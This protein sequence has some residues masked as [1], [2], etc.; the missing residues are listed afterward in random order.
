VD[1]SRLAPRELVP[2]ADG[3][4][5]RFGRTVLVFRDEL[6]GPLAPAPPA[7]GLLVGPYGLRSVAELLQGLGRSAPR[8]VLVEG[9]TG[10]GKELAARAV[11]AAL[12]RAEPFGAVNVAALAPGVFESHVFGHVAGAFSGSR[13]AEPGLVRALSGGT[14]FLDEIG[15]LGL[16]LQ[17]KLLRTIENGE[18]LPVGARRAEHVDVAFVAATNRNLEEMVEKGDFR[19]DLFAR[20]S[21]ARLRLPPLRD[22]REDVFFVARELFRRS[23]AELPEQQ[24]EV[25]AVE[26]LLLE[27][28]P[29]NVR[30]LD[31]ALAAV[32]RLDPEPG[33]PHWALVDVL[34]EREGHGSALTGEAIEAAVK[35]AGG[36]VTAAAAALGVSRGKLLRLRKRER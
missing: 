31:A 12:G 8:C 4:V 25:E 11:A 18:V 23:G 33:L 32:R 7:G 29:G 35:A 17:P 34:G 28:W 1:G 2:I 10:A 22:R 15:E 27:P 13:G 19:R 30:E 16:D 21:M 9:E 36:N 6:L 14:L 20:L 5:L 3:A 24:V 26:R